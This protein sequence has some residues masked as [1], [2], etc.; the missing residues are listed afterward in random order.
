MKV[1]AIIQDLTA[2]RSGKL[3]WLML[4]MPIPMAELGYR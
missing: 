2:S 1:I 4:N 3:G